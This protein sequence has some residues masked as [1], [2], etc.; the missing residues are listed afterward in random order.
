MWM[1]DPRRMCQQHLLGE[2]VEIHM[3]AG[4]LRIGRRVDG[5]IR[6][7]LLAPQLMRRRHNA[8]AAEMTRRGYKHKSPLPLT[9][10]RRPAGKVSIRRSWRDLKARCADCGS[11]R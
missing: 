1:V 4:S 10:G 5:Y 11:T 6:D 8:L 2:H 9:P 3:L 7:G